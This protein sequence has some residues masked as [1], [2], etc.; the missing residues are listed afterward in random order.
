MP[1]IEN[2]R[3]VIIGIRE[4]ANRSLFAFSIKAIGSS[5]VTFIWVSRAL[6]SLVDL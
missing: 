5:A 4:I 1:R 3:A 2:I 6:I